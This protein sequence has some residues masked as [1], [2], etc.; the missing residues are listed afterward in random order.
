[1]LLIKVYPFGTGGKES[2]ARLVFDGISGDSIAV[3]MIDMGNRLRL[4]CAEITLIEQPKPMPKLPVARLMWKLKPD[5][6]TGV[7]AWIYAGGEQF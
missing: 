5:F 1:M 3:S 6:R 7:A 2:S 4:V